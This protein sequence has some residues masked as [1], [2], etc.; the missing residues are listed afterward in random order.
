MFVFAHN[1]FFILI[2]FSIFLFL[3]NK[4]TLRVE[5]VWHDCFNTHYFIFSIIFFYSTAK[6]KHKRRH[7]LCAHFHS[8]F[9]LI[10]NNCCVCVSDCVCWCGDSRTHN[11]FCILRVCVWM[12]VRA[13][14]VFF[15]SFFIVR[16]C[17]MKTQNHRAHV[18]FWFE[19][20]FCYICVRVYEWVIVFAF[21]FCFF[22]VLFFWEVCVG[23]CL[24]YLFL[25]LRKKKSQK[26]NK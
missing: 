21:I 6:W 9:F 17:A 1:T 15:H 22:I 26:K 25:F 12:Y 24:L 13:L 11:L 14:F 16:F 5:R 23:V 3:S 7:I 4:L 19:F 10:R 18:F 8:F 2:L 20:F